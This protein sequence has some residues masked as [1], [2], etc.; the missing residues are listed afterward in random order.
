L[1]INGLR[2][3]LFRDT[4]RGGD[5]RIHLG[6]ELHIVKLRMR[7]KS[8]IFVLYAGN[9]VG[10]DFEGTKRK[11]LGNGLTPWNSFG[12]G[13]WIRTNDLR[14]MSAIRKVIIKRYLKVVN[15]N[16]VNKVKWLSNKS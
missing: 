2:V 10:N 16:N 8:L 5:I 6:D 12:S 15:D 4:T 3:A 1:L 9:S 13:G 11:G 14:V 7:Q